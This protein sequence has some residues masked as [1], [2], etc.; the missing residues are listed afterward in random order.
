MG[1]AVSKLF[2]GRQCQ[3]LW[4]RRAY[5]RT[6]CVDNAWYS[7]R[8]RLVCSDD[9]AYINV[10]FSEISVSYFQPFLCAVRAFDQNTAHEFAVLRY[11]LAAVILF[12]YVYN[13]VFHAFKTFP[14]WYWWYYNYS[15]AL[16]FFK[17]NILSTAHDRAFLLGRLLI[18]C[19]ISLQPVDLELTPGGTIWVS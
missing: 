5:R 8:G 11:T 1:G 7:R 2:Q 15:T 10:V 4:D 13:F 16:I 6:A 12:T 18:K 17:R 3:R 9:T 14:V 19:K